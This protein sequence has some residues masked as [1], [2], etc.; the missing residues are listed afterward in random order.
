MIR[1]RV[2]FAAGLATLCFIIYGSV[3]TSSIYT[4]TQERS[5]S[6][7]PEWNDNTESHNASSSISPSTY[8]QTLSAQLQQ[9]CK[10]ITWWSRLRTSKLK[11]IVP[12]Y[13]LAA[14]DDDSINGLAELLG[15]LYHRDDVFVIH[16]D[17]KVEED[18]FNSLVASI[19]AECQNIKFVEKR[20]N[21]WWAS[22]EIV[23]M[24]RQ[25]LKTALEMDMHWDTAM[26]MDGTCRPLTTRAKR[27]EWLQSFPADANSV[28]SEEYGPLQS[29]CLEGGDPAQCSRTPAR[30]L[31]DPAECKVMSHT[32]GSKRLLV[33]ATESSLIAYSRQ[34][35][36][37]RPAMD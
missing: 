2:A 21:V 30:C 1:R 10:P 19:P 23:E 15:Q 28:R 37:Q 20:I 11:S 17:A 9:D 18:V 27:Q 25:M 14:H 16:I 13:L 26:T 32:P 22:F 34:H 7:S 12:A 31:D 6:P 29:I 36:P 8:W 33:L 5:D 4:L 3:H 24:E 35:C